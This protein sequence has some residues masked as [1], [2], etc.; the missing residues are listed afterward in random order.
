MT[1]TG[2]KTTDEE[3]Q[4]AIDGV[5]NGRHEDFEVIRLTYLPLIES[6]IRSFEESGA[7]NQS[8]LYDEAVRALLRAVLA[9]DASG[10]NITFGLYAK[11]CIRNALISVRRAKLTREKR[12][13][14]STKKSEEKKHRRDDSVFSGMTAEEIMSKMQSVLSPYE[15]RVLRKY[16]SGAAAAEIAKALSKSERSVNNALYR[17]RRK[18]KVMVK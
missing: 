18:A 8:D 10:K 12:E 9:F 14:R 1:N 13:M 7:G 2:K 11:I 15:Y 4:N 17:I 6:T 5:K 3:I 16:I